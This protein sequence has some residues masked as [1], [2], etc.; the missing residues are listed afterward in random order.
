MVKVTV[1]SVVSRKLRIVQAYIDNQASCIRARKSKIT[2]L[3]TE[4]LHEIK[5]LLSWVLANPVGDTLYRKC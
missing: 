3:E 2:D 4:D 5:L 1:I